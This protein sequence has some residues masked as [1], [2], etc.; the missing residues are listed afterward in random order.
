MNRYCPHSVR[1][2]LSEFSLNLKRK[3]CHIFINDVCKSEKCLWEGRFHK[4]RQRLHVF[5]EHK[6]KVSC[7]NVYRAAR[8]HHS[9]HCFT[10]SHVSVSENSRT[11]DM[12]EVYKF[13]FFFTVCDTKKKDLG[14]EVP[15]LEYREGICGVSLCQGLVTMLRW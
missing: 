7:R 6:R 4:K 9:L 1:I 3:V 2:P 15:K 14:E 12:L 10:M 11:I 13:V 5:F 8:C